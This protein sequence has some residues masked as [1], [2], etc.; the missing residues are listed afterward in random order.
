MSE[1]ACK[2]S[3]GSHLAH[4]SAFLAPMA[5]ITDLAFR[6]QAERH[7]AGMVVSE[8][9][10]SNALATGNKEMT[11]RLGKPAR[12]PHMVQ[13]AGCEAEWMTRGAK[14]AHD[15]GADIIDIN[16]GCPSKRVTNG[17]AGSALMRV[18]DQAMRL[19]DAVVAATPLPVTVKMRLGWDDDS[20]NAADMARRAVDAGVQMISVHGR[21]RQQIY[22]GSARWE[23]VRAVVDAVDVPVVVNGDITDLAAAREALLLSGAA[24]VM[25]G[26]GAQGQPWRVGQIGAGLAG[27]VA[28]PAPQGAALVALITE[29]YEDMLG[30]YGIA[31]GLRAARKHLGWYAE[32]AGIALDK[33]VRTALLNSETPAEVLSMI[34][35]IFADDRK[36]AA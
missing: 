13:L 3:I 18:P 15:A 17:F 34:R 28:A 23:L 16:F 1:G 33:P 7:G 6:K 31:V 12:L 8:M 9:I 36:A 24:A 25:L 11:R 35:S 32:A 5:G 14:L 2:L 21:T 4:N 29:H 22:K 30:E 10:A 27:Q 19:V 26:R 20:L